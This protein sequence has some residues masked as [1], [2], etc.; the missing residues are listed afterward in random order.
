MPSMR[1]LSW[2][3]TYDWASLWSTP[4]SGMIREQ[5]SQT[6]V[7]WTS[8][9]QDVRVHTF[10]CF[11]PNSSSSRNNNRC[12]IF[13]CIWL[14]LDYV[15]FIQASSEPSSSCLL[16]ISKYAFS[17]IFDQRTLF[18]RV[19]GG[20]LKKIPRLLFCGNVVR[21]IMFKHNV[22]NPCRLLKTFQICKIFY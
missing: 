3:H 22:L 2:Q 8:V 6:Y 15:I 21:E 14:T 9:L 19:G 20:N 17:N 13:K 1:H 5:S 16:W 11:S 7:P 4:F 10:C 12:F 18:D